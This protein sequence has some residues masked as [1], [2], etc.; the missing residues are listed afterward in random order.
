MRV[1][2]SI[3]DNLLEKIDEYAKK[4]YLSRSGFISMA[5]VQY[6]NQLEVADAMNQLNFLLEKL[7]LEGKADDET[8]KQMLALQSVVD[9]IKK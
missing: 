5:S 3:D 6:L 8:K 7:V 9:A 1:Q 2:I 4:N